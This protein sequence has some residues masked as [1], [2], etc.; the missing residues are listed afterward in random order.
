MNN[1]IFIIII[2]ILLL[3]GVFFIPRFLVGRAI[4]KV[5]RIFRQQGAIEARQ[6]KSIEELG[7]ASPRNMLNMFSFRDY[8]PVALQVLMSSNI[9]RATE[10]NKYYLSEDTLA[11]SRMSKLY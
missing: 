10:D 5:L 2:F 1:I 9:I 6:A 8:K 7:L 11:N 3:L 4:K